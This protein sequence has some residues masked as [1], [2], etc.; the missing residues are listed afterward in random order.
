MSL[1]SLCKYLFTSLIGTILL[2]V[3]EYAVHIYFAINFKKVVVLRKYKE[4]FFSGSSVLEEGV[5]LFQLSSNEEPRFDELCR[6]RH[7]SIS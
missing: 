4:K 3:I 7:I 6:L 2:F 1:L 5:I